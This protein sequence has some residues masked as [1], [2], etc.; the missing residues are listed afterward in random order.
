MGTIEAILM[1]M[2][3]INTIIVMRKN[4]LETR[5]PLMQQGELWQ[6]ALEPQGHLTN[7]CN[8]LI[9]QRQ[10]SSKQP[11]T[12]RSYTRE[13]SS[14]LGIFMPHISHDKNIKINNKM[15]D[16]VLTKNNKK[17]QPHNTCATCHA[18]NTCWTSSRD[19][20][21]GSASDTILSDDK[22]SGSCNGNNKDKNYNLH[23]DKN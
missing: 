3:V 5:A 12:K 17:T 14:R 8:I 19:N 2:D 7:K 16:K 22:T 20:M 23:F 15:C 13:T 6:S 9:L 21:P 1:A 4:A 10:S 11:R 18:R